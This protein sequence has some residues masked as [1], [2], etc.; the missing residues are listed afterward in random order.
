MNLLDADL[1]ETVRISDISALEY[2]HKQRLIELGFTEDAEV[3]P[4]LSSIFSGIRAYRIKNTTIAL[5]D[6]ITV[7]I[8][9]AHI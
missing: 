4:I 6:D 3:T 8:K 5:R 2:S 9:V 7:M 1:N